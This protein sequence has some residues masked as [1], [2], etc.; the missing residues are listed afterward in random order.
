MDELYDTK[1]AAKLL[2]IEKWKLEEMRKNGLAV[3]SHNL[4]PNGLRPRPGYSLT[5]IAEI[6]AL[7]QWKPVEAEGAG[8]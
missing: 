2:G 1:E 7:M 3:P 6:R 5:R 8:K 4:N